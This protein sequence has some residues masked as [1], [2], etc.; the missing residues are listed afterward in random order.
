MLLS[1]PFLS[2]R[3]LDLLTVQQRVPFDQ[4]RPGHSPAVLR[5]CS[6]RVGLGLLR[7]NVQLQSNRLA[8]GSG[9]EPLE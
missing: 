1:S 3:V 8:L 4:E 9:N 2:P 7:D 6:I 5:C